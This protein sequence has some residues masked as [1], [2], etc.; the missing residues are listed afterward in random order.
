MTLPSG[1]LFTENLVFNENRQS[2]WVEFIRACLFSE[3]FAF[4]NPER[5]N[6]NKNKI[7]STKIP[8]GTAKDETY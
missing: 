5:K 1:I 2:T 6:F 3:S 4:L 7:L 8:K